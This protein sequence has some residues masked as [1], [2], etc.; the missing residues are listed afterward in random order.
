M[1][2]VNLRLAVTVEEFYNEDVQ[3]SFINRIS[4]Y[5]GIS[6]NRIKIVG[7]KSSSSRLR[8]LLSDDTAETTVIFEIQSE[9]TISE[10]KNDTYSAYSEY[11]TFQ[12]ISQ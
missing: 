1:V 11:V 6:A 3:T 12:N 4:A 5:L 8:R 7:L 2:Q 10:S 9:T